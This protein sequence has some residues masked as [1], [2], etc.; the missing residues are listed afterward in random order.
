MALP[1][2]KTIMHGKENAHGKRASERTTKSHAQQSHIRAHGK[3]KPHGKEGIQCMV[4]KTG[5]APLPCIETIPCAMLSS[6]T[7]EPL[8]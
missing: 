6:T 8:P 1:C 4:K 5:T 3:D 7:K 2:D